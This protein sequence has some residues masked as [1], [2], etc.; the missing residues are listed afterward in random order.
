MADTVIETINIAEITEGKSKGKKTFWKIKTTDDEYYTCWKQDVKD[1]L[2]EGMNT[3]SLDIN[4][5][6]DKIFKNIVGIAPPP[7]V[8][9]EGYLAEMGGGAPGPAPAAAPAAAQ[10]TQRGQPIAS[11]APPASTPPPAPSQ[12]LQ[13][14]GGMSHMQQVRSVALQIAA[15]MVATGVIKTVELIPMSERNVRYILDGSGE[16]KSSA[17]ATVQ[18]ADYVDR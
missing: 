9:G 17:A 14:P 8:N 12:P 16:Q 3:V 7:E 5:T 6:G 1:R 13:Q 11:V 10:T 2:V 15:G 4:D 18:A